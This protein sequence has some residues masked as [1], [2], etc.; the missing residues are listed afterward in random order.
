MKFII[1]VFT[2]LALQTVADLSKDR[3]I[4]QESVGALSG[5]SST[6]WITRRTG[7]ANNYK[8]YVRRPMKKRVNS[9]GQRISKKRPS[10]MPKRNHLKP[11]YPKPKP[12]RRPIKT[13]V[14]S[15]LKNKLPQRPIS[16]RNPPNA[17]I[18]DKQ[19]LVPRP[20]G[21]A[22]PFGLSPAALLI[23]AI[24]T[25]VGKLRKPHRI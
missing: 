6:S 5:N 8:S 3:N 24:P 12:Q 15:N 20:I 16:T 25:L 4:S 19:F 1:F 22:F 21:P 10:K 7:K 11:K 14:S 2:V 18:Q 23:P 17:K 13:K 9:K